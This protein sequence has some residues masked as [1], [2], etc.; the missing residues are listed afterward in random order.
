MVLLASLESYTLLMEVTGEKIVGG[1]GEERKTIK[2]CDSTFS[3][4]PI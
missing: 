2:K 3:C 1:T 4:K